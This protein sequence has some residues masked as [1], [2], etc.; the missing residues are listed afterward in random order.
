ML[1][2]MVPQQPKLTKISTT[3]LVPKAKLSEK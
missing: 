1:S 2:G 3:V